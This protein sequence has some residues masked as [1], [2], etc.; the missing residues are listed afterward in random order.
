MNIKTLFFLLSLS[1]GIAA[2][3]VVNAVETG[4]PAPTCPVK[5]FDDKGMLDLSKYKGKVVYMDFWASWCLPC[6]KSFPFMN[7][8]QQELSPR[9][10]E[11]VAINL[12]EK[13]QDAE[14]FLARYPAG[15]TVAADPEGRCPAL[16]EV[17]G[18]PSSYLID[19][20]G[21]VRHVHLGFRTEDQ[22]KIRAHIEALLAEK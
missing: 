5:T 9:G 4:Q 8:L 14:T 18:M 3:P 20:Q 17:K 15:F 7:E 13:R 6:A 10:L 12:D 16:F 21:T 19:R 1:A 2:L 11:V 22:P